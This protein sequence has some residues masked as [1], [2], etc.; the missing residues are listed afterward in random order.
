MCSISKAKL[1]F[2]LPY[3]VTLMFLIINTPSC[4]GS[5]KFCGQK[6][7]QA[8]SVIC[9]GSYPN[10]PVKKSIAPEEDYK[11]DFEDDFINALEYSPFMSKQLLE[12]LTKT[13]RR[14]LGIAD[15]CCKKAC[16][17]DELK[18]YCRPKFNFRLN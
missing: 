10:I 3:L 11:S 9:D 18:T 15:E 13:R 16:T 4:E 1:L 17:M 2:T 14:R 6:L 7:N 8:L 5:E 12:T